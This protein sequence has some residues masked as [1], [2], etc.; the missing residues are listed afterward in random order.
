MTITTNELSLLTT[1]NE[2]FS[3]KYGDMT[4]PNERYSWNYYIAV[5]DRHDPAEWSQVEHIFTFQRITMR[6]L[7]LYCVAHLWGSGGKHHKGTLRLGRY[8]DYL[9]YNL[10]SDYGNDAGIPPYEDLNK[11][12]YTSHVSME[13]LWRWLGALEAQPYGISRR[14]C[15]NDIH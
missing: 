4:M 1:N 5:S 10:I 9:Q 12:Q 14:K 6:I 3:F 8:E 13:C 2:T 15:H 7:Q 11:I